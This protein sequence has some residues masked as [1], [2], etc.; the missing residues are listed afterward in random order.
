MHELNRR[1]IIIPEGFDYTRQTDDMVGAMLA[2]RNWTL[3]HLLQA[4]GLG[5]RAGG[6]RQGHGQAE[7]GAAVSRWATTAC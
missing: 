2:D 1:Q 4:A 5:L 6:V 3:D 7:E